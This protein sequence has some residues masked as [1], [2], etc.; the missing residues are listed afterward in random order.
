MTNVLLTGG[1]NPMT[2]ALARLL[3][4]SGATV[5]LSDSLYLPF[6]RYSKS[7]AKYFRLPHASE[8]PERFI[9]QLIKVI[10][11]HGI[12]LLIP[13]NEE[14]FFIARFK[15][16]FSGICEVACDDFEKLKRFHHKYELLKAVEGCG[17]KT[18]ETRLVQ[19]NKQ[20]LGFLK[21]SR[22]FIFKPVYSRFSDEILISPQPEKLKKINPTAVNPYIAQ[23]VIPGHEYC[24]YSI[25]RDGRITAHAA[26]E[27]PYTMG[28]GS[29]IYFKK[30]MD[31]RIESFCRAF[32]ARH[33]F[34]G[35]IGFDF[36]RDSKGDYYIIDCNPRTTSGLH[37]FDRTDGI[38]QAL[39]GAAGA[40]VYPSINGNQM[41]SLTLVSIHGL[42]SVLKGTFPAFLRNIFNAEDV[43][44]RA[45][46]PQPFFA[47][48]QTLLEF[49]WLSIVKRI[50]FRQAFYY[51]N[52]WN[53]E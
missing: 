30:I 43:I 4:A 34:T 37:L 3:H 27:H 21:N 42:R 19:N 52:G 49:V 13:T 47:Q 7:V 25:S 11:D 46:D 45:D 16:A 20:V 2:L 17:F 6:A 15:D 50:P 41:N 10:T 1:R 44:F 26:Y 51:G 38:L 32:C 5:F 29:G 18:P 35:Q 22:E 24:S 33:Q 36:I 23:S 28:K 9:Q 8:S 39:T 31:N 14:I 53:G 48:T 12:R 40:C